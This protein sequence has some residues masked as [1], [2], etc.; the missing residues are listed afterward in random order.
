MENIHPIIIE[1]EGHTSISNV[2]AFSG[3]NNAL[4]TVPENKSWDYLLVKGDKK[5]TVSIWGSRMRNYVA[6]PPISIENDQ[7]IIQVVGCFDRDENLYNKTFD[8]SN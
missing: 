8:R 2:E 1:G 4:T 5:L 3:G 7:A 6:N